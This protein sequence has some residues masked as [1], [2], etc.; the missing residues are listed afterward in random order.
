MTGRILIQAPDNG[1]KHYRVGTFVDERGRVTAYTTWYNK[2]WAGC[3]EL[4]V[5]AASGA[6]A[7]KAAILARKEMSK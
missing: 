1:R 5:M 4:E 7:K 3:I 6:S 2:T